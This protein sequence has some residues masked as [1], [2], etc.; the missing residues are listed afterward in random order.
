MRGGG[1]AVDI[2]R[3]VF[4]RTYCSQVALKAAPKTPAE[5]KSKGLTRN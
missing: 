2:G 4:R 1:E 3:F 5:K